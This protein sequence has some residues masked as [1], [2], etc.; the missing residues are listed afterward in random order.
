M[1]TEDGKTGR[2]RRRRE[3]EILRVPVPEGTFFY[4]LRGSR[5]SDPGTLLRLAALLT[6]TDAEAA[7]RGLH[8]DNRTIRG[9]CELHTTSLSD[10]RH[11]LAALDPD[12]ARRRIELAAATGS[13]L[14]A[15]D[16]WCQAF[17]S[18]AGEFRRLATMCVQR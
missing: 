12:Q 11:L 5:R 3:P 7:L 8:A 17:A 1:E 15:S 10:A 13:E 18:V 2:K 9:V 16:R 14:I 6:G 4:V